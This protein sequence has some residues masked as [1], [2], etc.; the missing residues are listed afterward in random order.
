MP[1]N[2][3]N[4]KAISEAGE[5]IYNRLYKPE[6]EQSQ[7]GKFVAINILDESATLG[8][9]AM[10]ALSSAKAK[11]PKGLFH[12][13]RVGHSGAFEV[14]IAYRHVHTDRVR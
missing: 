2:F 13:I 11:Y 8:D 5:K 1:T 7:Q 9:T 6:F 10:E 4:P 3:N 14:G 12:L